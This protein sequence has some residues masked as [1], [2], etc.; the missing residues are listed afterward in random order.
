MAAMRWPARATRTTEAPPGVSGT[1]RVAGAGAG[2]AGSAYL[3]RLGPG[4]VAVIDQVDLDRATATALLDAGVVGV[5]NAA[6]SISGRYPNLGP[7]ILV[8]AGVVLVDDCGPGVF[9]DVT[10][11]STVRLHDGAVH[12]GPREVLR[13]FAQ[14][15]DTVA[16]LLDEAR[17]G[18]AAQLEAFSANTSEFL[19]RERGLLVDGLG[20]PAVATTMR[21]RHV[22]VVAG[23]PGTL[24]ELRSIAGYLREHQPVLVGVGEGAGALREAGHSPTVVLGTVAELDPALARRATD[25]VVPADSDGHIAGLA[26][27]QDLGVDPVPFA[28]SANPEDMALLLAHAHGASLVVAVGFDASLGG[29]LDR[30]RS[31]SIPSTFLTRLRLGTTLVDAPAVRALHR[32]RGSATVLALLLASVLAAAV[33]AAVALGAG[34]A[35]LELLGSW[36][37][38][39]AAWATDVVRSVVG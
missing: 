37:R 19:G 38:A 12:L 14:D 28:S 5:V 26:R 39:I 31:G 17:G 15:R 23:G 1:A 35:L 3:R 32:T 25:V 27:L 21:D 33:V 8:E 4:D 20:V 6:P 18:M 30:G 10:D 11:G 7:E 13:G 34:P 22:V 24:D 16:D 2:G 9:S 36:G 29:F